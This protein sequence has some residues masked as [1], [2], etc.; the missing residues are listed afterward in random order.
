MSGGVA[1]VLDDGT[2][3]KRVNPGMVDILPVEGDF[4][5]ELHDMIGE[6]ARLTGSPLAQDMLDHWDERK[7][8]F[9]MIIPR[10]YRRLLEGM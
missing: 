6:H 10:E 4:E 7:S 2:L 5:R 3:E 8:H 1:Y 9:R